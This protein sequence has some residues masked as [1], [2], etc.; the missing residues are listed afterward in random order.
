[1]PAGDPVRRLKRSAGQPGELGYWAA[2]CV[3]AIMDSLY[4]ARNVP[5]SAHARLACPHLVTLTEDEDA[6]IE[7]VLIATP[8][9]AWR[10][11]GS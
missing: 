2:Y 11:L 4:A 1:M 7:A 10:R 8:P 5:S 6:L 9:D 3:D